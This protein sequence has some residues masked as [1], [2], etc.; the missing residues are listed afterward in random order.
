MKL[1]REKALELHYLMWGDMQNDLGDSPAPALRA[2]YKEAWIRKHFPDQKVLHNC[3]LC[4]FVGRSY[5]GTNKCWNCPI[6]WDSLAV[7]DKGY[8]FEEYKG[9]GDEGSIYLDAP[10]SEILELPE[11]VVE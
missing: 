11:R 4:E 2:K 6:N 9:G 8:C 1:T 3:F 5:Y 7:D 10:I